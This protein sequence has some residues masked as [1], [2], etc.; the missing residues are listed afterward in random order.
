MLK[1]AI[2][3]VIFVY[4]SNALAGGE[5]GHEYHDHEGEY[6]EGQYHEGQYNEGQ[7]HEG[8]HQGHQGYA[9][10]GYQSLN[11]GYPAAVHNQ[12]DYEHEHGEYEHEHGEYE[13]GEHGEYEHEDHYNQGAP[14]GHNQ[15]TGN[16]GNTG[17]TAGYNSNS[18][19][20]NNGQTGQTG[21][22]ANGSNAHLKPVGNMVIHSPTPTGF[23]MVYDVTN[24]DRAG[25][26]YYSVKEDAPG[27]V[28][29]AIKP[30]INDI[31]MGT[32][33]VCANRFQQVDELMD[34][35]SIPCTLQAGKHY[36][37]WC[38]TDRDSNGRDAD[39]CNL[40]IGGSLS[41]DAVGGVVAHGATGTGVAT[42]GSTGQTGHGT[43]PGHTGAGIPG[44]VPGY[45]LVL[46]DHTCDFEEEA[47]M[48]VKV[49]AN[50]TPGDT[51]GCAKAVSL[52]TECGVTFYGGGVRGT[53]GCVRKTAETRQTLQGGL[54]KFV[55][56]DEEE[57]KSGDG[58]YSFNVN[59]GILL[60]SSHP[61]NN[62]EANVSSKSWFTNDT[63]FI[64][65]STY[66]FACCCLGSI[67][68]I[69]QY[70]KK[71][72]SVSNGAYAIYLDEENA[73]N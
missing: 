7:Y 50:T 63:L 66:C 6:H 20:Y 1:S 69:V 16:T 71:Q 73:R 21:Y 44:L 14:Y 38:A 19:G 39:Y 60:A 43:A 9:S 70:R 56:C 37:V 42:H 32:G 10:T 3:L 2:I 51:D 40:G 25:S 35:K 13:H 46:G 5:H 72:N 53:C 15:P 41:L 36:T 29:A 58:I 65:L 59:S 49:L 17:S 52:D 48:F 45:R 57:S 33:A 4:L 24:P 12:G 62:A 55:A 8:Q 31:R 30:P 22:N 61:M 54:G 64:I 26:F 67:F 34:V 23:T 68:G 18:S 11:E 27:A 47:G 28:S